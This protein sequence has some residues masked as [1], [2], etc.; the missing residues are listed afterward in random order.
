MKDTVLW[1]RLEGLGVFCAALIY[2][3]YL[4]S[5]FPIWVSVLIFFAPDLSFAAYAAGP[6]IGALVYN[7]VHVYALGAILLVAGL[8][9]ADPAMAGIGALMLA[10]TGF[11]RALG[12]GL[13]TTQ[14][15]K[16]THLGDL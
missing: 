8:L 1:Q 2:F 5:G 4:D 6:K 11:D 16:H 10:H 3:A 12:Y 15:F 7:L 13:K 9:T 14:G